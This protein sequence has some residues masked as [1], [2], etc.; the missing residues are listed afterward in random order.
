MKK[1]IVL[2]I[3][4]AVVSLVL[5]KISFLSEKKVTITLN[6]MKIKMDETTYNDLIDY[7]Y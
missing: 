1:S 2:I 6:D 7:G 5:F 4:I 3:A